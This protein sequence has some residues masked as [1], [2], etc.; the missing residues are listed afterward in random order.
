MLL[1]ILGLVVIGLYVYGAE[2]EDPDGESEYQ[3][4]VDRYSFYGEESS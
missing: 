1:V 4:Q 2:N 3:D